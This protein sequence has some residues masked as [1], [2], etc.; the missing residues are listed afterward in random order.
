MLSKLE[1]YSSVDVFGKDVDSKIYDLTLIPDLSSEQFAGNQTGVALELKLM[2]F[3]KLVE[4][5][6]VEIEKLYRRRLKMYMYFLWQKGMATFDA[7]DVEITINR[8]WTNNMLE[9]AQ[10]IATLTPTGLYSDEYLTNQMPDADYATEKVRK[11]TEGKEKQKAM[12]DNPDPNNAVNS[13]IMALL[14]NNEEEPK[15]QV[16]NVN[17]A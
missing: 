8:N 17:T 13:Q 10:L 14:R 2:P 12:I 15:V 1:D 16:P 5:K 7:A 11:E 9:I 3:K 6:D 4:A